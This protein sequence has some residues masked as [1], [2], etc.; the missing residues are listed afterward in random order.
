MNKVQIKGQ[1]HRVA[2]KVQDAVALSCRQRARFK[3]V[4]AMTKKL[5]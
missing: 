4:M 1:T 3:R 5:P 2:S